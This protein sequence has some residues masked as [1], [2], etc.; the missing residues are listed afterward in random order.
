MTRKRRRANAI[1]PKRVLIDSNLL[2]LQ[3]VGDYQPS[4]IGKGRTS[5]FAF[6]DYEL[7]TR[8]ISGF[9]VVVTTPHVLTEVS[10]LAGQLPLWV[11]ENLFRD[12]AVMIAVLEEQ[13]VPARQVVTSGHFAHF[14]LT[15]LAL[16]HLAKGRITVIT[17]D[18]RAAAYLSAAEA[19]V[20]DFNGLR[21]RGSWSH[22]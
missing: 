22:E 11:R 8:L 6:S 19:E 14:G 17:S 5:G 10:N 20:I 12:F 18:S 21:Q 9:D 4:L 3:L 1:A 7:L 2:I 15:D 16:A 13:F